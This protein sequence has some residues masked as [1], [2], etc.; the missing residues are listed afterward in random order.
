MRLW[1]LQCVLNKSRCAYPRDSGKIQATS[2]GFRREGQHGARQQLQNLDQSVYVRVARSEEYIEILTNDSHLLILILLLHG[3][4]F[5]PTAHKFFTKERQN[6]I[7][8]QKT[9]RP[10]QTP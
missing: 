2:Q 4:L 8:S 3:S 10:H 9:Q 6:L 1:H 7:S 5:F